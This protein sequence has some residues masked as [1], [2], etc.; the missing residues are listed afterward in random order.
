MIMWEIEKDI[1]VYHCLFVRVFKDKITPDKTPSK[2]AFVNTPKDG[3]NLS[4]DWCKYASAQTSR[5]LIRKQK[6][7]KGEYKN[8]NDFY[9]WKFHVLSLSEMDIPQTAEHEPIYNY[10]EID[11]TPNN[12]AH[13]KIIGQKLTNQAEFRMQI[14]RAGMWAIGPE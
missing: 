13:T 2:S 7:Q 9:I 14:N 6:N 4:S 11:G 8:A 3:D 10:P 5:E 12:R 1:N